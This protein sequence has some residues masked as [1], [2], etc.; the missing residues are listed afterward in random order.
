M[1]ANSMEA[2]S[3]RVLSPSA[4]LMKSIAAI[5]AGAIDPSSLSALS[6][7]ASSMLAATAAF[8]RASNAGKIGR[9][10]AATLKRA[11]QRAAGILAMRS[12]TAAAITGSSDGIHGA[13]PCVVATMEDKIQRVSGNSVP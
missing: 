9:A 1:K 5:R 3:K 8:R 13:D 2:S 4:A 11:T 6:M 12:S 10:G 7:N